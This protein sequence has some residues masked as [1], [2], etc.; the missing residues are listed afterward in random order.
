MKQVTSDG[1]FL[2]NVLRNLDKSEVYRIVHLSHNIF[3]PFKD[4]NLYINKGNKIAKQN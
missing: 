3:F 4:I 2:F 1:L